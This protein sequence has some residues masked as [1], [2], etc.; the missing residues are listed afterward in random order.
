VC[1]LQ[2]L[3]PVKPSKASGLVAKVY[4]QIKQDF[5]RIVEPFTL[6][7]PI[8]SIL[9]GAWMAA[10]ESELVGHAPRNV[11]EAIAA[12]ISKLNQ[13]PYCVDAHTIMLRASGEKRTAKLMAQE[14]YDE[15]KPDQT[16]EIVKWALSTLSP[17]SK[18][19]NKP[20]FTKELAPELIGTAVFY[21]YI[22]PLVTIFLGNSPLPLP[23]FKSQLKPIASRLFKKAVNSPKLP[24]DSLDLLPEAK[25]PEDLSWAKGSPNVSGAYARFAEAFS[26]LEGTVIPKRTQHIVNK[27]IDNWS[28]EIHKF[29]T[30]HLEE[31]ASHLK[32]E[33]KIATKIALLTVFSPYKITQENIKEFQN[34]FTQQELLGITAWASFTRARKIGINFIP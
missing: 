27:Y 25:L 17:K 22:N 8:P 23:F 28:G 34:F 33:L 24:G 20:P 31:I 7:S 16:K 32:P 3:V 29:G 18:L 21:H 4:S 13:C 19:I 14:Q 5:G 30:E 2:Y 9:A 12:S 10:R 26:D 11:K 6:H 15:I 1:F